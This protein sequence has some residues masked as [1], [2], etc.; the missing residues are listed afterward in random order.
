MGSFAVISLQVD[1]SRRS[2]AAELPP[3][4]S[5]RSRGLGTSFSTLRPVRFRSRCFFRETSAHIVARLRSNLIPTGDS[6]KVSL[7]VRRLVSEPSED[8]ERVKQTLE[9]GPEIWDVEFRRGH[10]V[11]DA[12]MSG[13]VLEATVVPSSNSMHQIYD[14]LLHLGIV[15]DGENIEVRST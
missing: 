6:A 9:E 8:A 10:Y 13:D 11:L 7:P 12:S 4:S 15:A 1:L 5:R 3:S 2:M 14:S